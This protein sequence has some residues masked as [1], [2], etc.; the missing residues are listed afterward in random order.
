MSDMPKINLAEAKKKLTADQYRIAVG[1]VNLKTGCLRASKPPVAKKTLSVLDRYFGGTYKDFATTADAE[2]GMTAFVWRMTAFMVS[3][4]PQHH[5]MPICAA[6]D[7]P[8]Q[9]SAEQ[10]EMEKRLQVI[11]DVL[12]DTVPRQEQHGVERW[13]KAFGYGG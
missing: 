7:L 11:A 9:C 4:N 6:F 1:C 3:P 8:G 2:S 10:R 12:V 13:A 5:C